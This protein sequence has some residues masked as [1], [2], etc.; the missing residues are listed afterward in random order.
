MKM[1]LTISKDILFAGANHPLLEEIRKRFTLPNPAYTS[2]KRQGR[3]TRHLEPELR[4][5]RLDGKDIVLPRGAAREV[6]TLARQHGPVEI[7]D[8][9][10]SLPEIDLTFQG[11]LR[12]YQ[13]QAVS[14]TLAKDFGVL[15]AGTGSGKTVMALP[16]IAARKQPALVI[17]HTKEL[18]HQWRER[19]RQFLGIETGLIGD[20]H[21]DIRPVTIGIVNS[22]RANLERLT[23]AFGHLVVDECHRVPSTLFTETVSAFQAK[24][25]LG[26]SATAFRRDGLD[27]LI[28][29]FIGQHRVT[30]DAEVLR[31]VGAIL[32]PRII[33]RET[34]FNYW[35]RDDYAAMLSA[36]VT[37]K[38]RNQL[39]ATDILEQSK[40]QCLSLVVSDR[41]THLKALAELAG[42]DHELLTGKTP[43]KKRREIVE[44]LQSGEVRTLFSTLSLIGEGFDCPSMD[45]LFLASPV[46]FSGRLKQVVGRV[47]R[48]AADKVPVVFDYQDNRVGILKHQAKARQKIYATM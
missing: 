11:S 45:A 37:N 18:L 10:L 28:G 26:L 33:C 25:M 3:W 8:N 30:V 22:V 41:V 38:E 47:L 35:Y 48:P 2:A 17:C 9:R 23:S 39:I 44:A 34:D 20:G 36:L 21:F 27:P 24:Y 31:Q 13:E 12:P 14:G 46:K 6:L 43:N 16:I 5:W 7:V 4:F 1:I 42:A 32:R 19:I 15:E 40:H 29:W